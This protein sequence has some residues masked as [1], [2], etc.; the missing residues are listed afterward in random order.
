[1][2]WDCIN[3]PFE[4]V[5]ACV[6]KGLRRVHG[7]DRFVAIRVEDTEVRSEIGVVRGD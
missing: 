1:M 4:D 2:L 3:H 7:F 5:K 6:F